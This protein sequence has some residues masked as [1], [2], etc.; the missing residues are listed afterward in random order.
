MDTQESS[1]AVNVVGVTYR[2]RSKVIDPV[3]KARE[4]VYGIA[5]MGAD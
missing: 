2:V 5:T 4:M 1:A 3:T